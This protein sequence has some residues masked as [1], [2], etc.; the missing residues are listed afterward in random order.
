MADLS[1]AI[2]FWKDT[3]NDDTHGYDQAHRNG[4]DYDC[5]SLIA[6]GLYRAGFKVDR[7]STTYNLYAQLR[8][9]GFTLISNSFDRKAG[10]IWLNVNHH[11]VASIDADNVVSASI[12]EKG[13]VTGG[14]TGDQTGKEISIKPWYLPAYG[15]DYHLR[16]TEQVDHNLDR[17][18]GYESVAREVITGKWN[19]GETRKELL[20]AAGWDYDAVQAIV[21]ILLRD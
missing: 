17:I 18:K 5:S 4:P 10:D 14:K 19:N 21:N 7:N 13:A 16:I 1:M 20:Q 8:A 12:N 6:E 9:C 15:W 3:A 11:V 2:K